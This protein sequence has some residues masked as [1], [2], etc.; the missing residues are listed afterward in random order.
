MRAHAAQ[1]NGFGDDAGETC[2]YDMQA[3]SSPRLRCPAESRS[4]TD[5][6]EAAPQHL[7]C[8]ACCVGDTLAEADVMW[9]SSV[10]R[11]LTSRQNFARARHVQ[12]R[13][14]WVQE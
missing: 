5:W 4:G 1:Y 8:R 13:R 6:C 12:P 9:D 2:V 14:L 11:G 7:G 10:G 3:T